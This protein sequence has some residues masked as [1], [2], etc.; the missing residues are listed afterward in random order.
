MQSYGKLVGKELAAQK[1]SWN[2]SFTNILAL[3]AGNEK[4]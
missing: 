4:L 2:K 3:F 1:A